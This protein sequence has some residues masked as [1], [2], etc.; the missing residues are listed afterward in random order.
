MDE[1]EHVQPVRDADDDDVVAAREVGAVVGQRRR[2]AAGIAAAVQPHHDGT[3]CCRPRGLG[4]Q[5]FRCRQSSLIGSVPVSGCHS[6]TNDA[7][8]CGERGPKA[9]ASRTPVHGVTGSGGRNRRAPA[10]DA[11]YGT[12]LNVCTPSTVRPRTRPAVV[13]T[14]APG[15]PFDP[16]ARFRAGLNSRPAPAI[17]VARKNRRRSIMSADHNTKVGVRLSPSQ[18]SSARVRPRS[19]PGPDLARRFEPKVRPWS[20]P[21]LTKVRKAGA[22]RHPADGGRRS[23]E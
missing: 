11:P 7:I 8:T 18:P 14:T 2:R 1:A 21:G 10:V 3:P 22:G 16:C 17:D 9:K 12:A 23:C 5:T 19:D 6:G 13:C 15:E 20:D 4:V